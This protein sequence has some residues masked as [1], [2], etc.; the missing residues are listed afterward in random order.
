M[1]HYSIYALIQLETPPTLEVHSTEGDIYTADCVLD[2]GERARI[3]QDDGTLLTCHSLDELH[4]R[5]AAVPFREARLI[6]HSAYDE[7][8][9]TPTHADPTPLSLHWP[10]NPAQR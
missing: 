4:S 1:K 5:L 3:S 8:I 10:A 2:S 9:G 7:M 6:Q